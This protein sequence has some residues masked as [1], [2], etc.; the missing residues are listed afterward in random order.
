MSV[1][2]R[3][4]SPID[5]IALIAAVRDHPEI[6]GNP[7]SASSIDQKTHTWRQISEKVNQPV[8]KCKAKWRNLRDSY[9]KAMKWKEELAEVGKLSRYREY[10]H[11]EALSFLGN[12]QKRKL[13]E[14]DKRTRL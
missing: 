9:L 3:Q 8:E 1:K 13:G 5:T 11:E 6:Y 2:E 7:L 12:G 10:K 4:N 14:Y